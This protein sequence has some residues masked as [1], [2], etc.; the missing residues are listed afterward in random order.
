MT[1]CSY[2]LLIRELSQAHSPKEDRTGIKA[3]VS[4]STAFVL[5]RDF[6]YI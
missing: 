2:T 4:F 6:R 3:K 5:S 1:Y